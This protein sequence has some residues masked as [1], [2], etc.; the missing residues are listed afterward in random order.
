MKIRGLILKLANC[1]QNFLAIAT[2]RRM[3]RRIVAA[4]RRTQANRRAAEAGCGSTSDRCT[5]AEADWSAY[6]HRAESHR[7]SRVKG[8]LLRK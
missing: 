2:A 4:N 8:T 1:R 3:S 5:A 7:A 6:R